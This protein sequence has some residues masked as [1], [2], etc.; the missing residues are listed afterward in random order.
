MFHIDNKRK[1]SHRAPLSRLSFFKLQFH[2]H[3]P[4]L[5]RKYIV[6]SP[7]MDNRWLS[8]PW[9]VFVGTRLVAEYSKAYVDL[10]AGSM[11]AGQQMHDL[12]SYWIPL[13]RI[14]QLFH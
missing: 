8:F 12:A 7:T 10:A 9:L 11:Q 5:L 3:M 6:G 1:L 13:V 14:V 2:N 4:R